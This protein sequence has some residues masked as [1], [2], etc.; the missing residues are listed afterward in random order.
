MYN[1]SNNTEKLR[2]FLSQQQQIAEYKA[3][4]IAYFVPAFIKLL[5]A[6]IYAQRLTLPWPK[7]LKKEDVKG[8]PN[9]LARAVRQELN[10]KG[11]SNIQI[12]IN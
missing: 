7:E 12:T 1:S 2:N 8:P 4:V 11:Y 3:K 5:E 9:W 6:S 10:R